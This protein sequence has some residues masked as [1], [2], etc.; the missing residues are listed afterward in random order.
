MEQSRAFF[1]LLQR[2]ADPDQLRWEEL[3]P[4][5]E[6]H[7]LYGRPGQGPA[8]ALLRYAPGA[9][10]PAH[11]HT[12]YEH[13]LVLRGSQ[14]DGA[15]HYPAGTLLVSPPGSRHAVVSDQGCVVLAIWAGP[16]DFEINGN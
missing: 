3:R 2:A 8:A 4:G 13:I 12:D 7:A 9:A 15:G 10:V 16:I 6:F 14:R 11:R 5:V 1:E